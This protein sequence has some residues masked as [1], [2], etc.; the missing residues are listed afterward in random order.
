MRITIIALSMLF[1]L[2]RFT[3]SGQGLSWPGSYEAF[4][5]IWVGFLIAAAIYAPGARRFSLWAL[6]AITAIEIIAFL[7]RGWSLWDRAPAF[8]IVP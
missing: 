8:F 2:G 1:A 6:A 7:H 4:A 5:H 3:A